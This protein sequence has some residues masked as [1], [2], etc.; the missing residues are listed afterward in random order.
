MSFWEDIAQAALDTA[1]DHPY[2]TI[3]G[4]LLLLALQLWLEL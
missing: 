1:Y 4:V 3:G 2:L